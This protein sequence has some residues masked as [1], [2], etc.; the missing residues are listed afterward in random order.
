MSSDGVKLM[1][2]PD[3]GRIDVV[4][5][6]PDW[7]METLNQHYDNLVYWW[8]HSPCV[9]AVCDSCGEW[10]FTGSRSATRCFR[11]QVNKRAKF[12]WGCQGTMK[13]VE[14]PWTTKRPNRKRVKIKEKS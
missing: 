7:A 3:R 11:G 9:L 2:T 12:K 14:L 5:R 4:G 10:K 13:P 1:A 8:R 6:L